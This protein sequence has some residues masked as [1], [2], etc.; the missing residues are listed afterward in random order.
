MRKPTVISLFA[1]VGGFDLGFVDA[2]YSI[3]CSTDRDKKAMKYNALNFK[4][5]ILCQDVYKVCGED[6]TRGQHI[7]VVI[8]GAPCQGFSMAGN[9]DVLDVRNQLI[10]EYVRLVKEIE[11]RYFVFENV[12]GILT[13]LMKPIFD[14]FCIELEEDYNIKYAVLDASKYDVAQS[15]KRVIVLGWRE[16]E[17]EP[18]FPTES[19]QIK[20]VREAF[21]DVPFYSSVMH[22]QKRID[23]FKLIRPGEACLVSLQARRLYW[24]KPAFTV[25]AY[26]KLIHPE[27]HRYINNREAARLQSFPDSFVID[28]SNSGGARQVGNAVPPL[29][30]YA[31]ATEL[32]KV[33]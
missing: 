29:L 3:V 21:L 27:Y 25:T 17:L 26:L 14:L 13:K 1:G 9:R 11:P 23:Q 33:L 22:S 20:T 18:N 4:H 12:G 24:D 32:K 16:G 5:R 2:G 30:A 6:L 31:I 7:D 8:G 19:Q 28:P 10:F 15:R